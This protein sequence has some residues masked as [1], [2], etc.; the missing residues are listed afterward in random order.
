MKMETIKVVMNTTQARKIV[1]R[2]VTLQH[3]GSKPVM[4]I[5]V[6]DNL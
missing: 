4:D 1:R 3:V 6:E 2:N 5:K